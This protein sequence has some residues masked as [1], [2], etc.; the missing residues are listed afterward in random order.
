MSAKFVNKTR[1][2]TIMKSRL[3]TK[4]AIKKGLGIIN[5]VVGVSAAMVYHVK[6]IGIPPHLALRKP[7]VMEDSIERFPNRRGIKLALDL[8][9]STLRLC[10]FGS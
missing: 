7:D 8:P 9:L 10:A 2:P 1:Q 3:R 4:H 6:N 5:G